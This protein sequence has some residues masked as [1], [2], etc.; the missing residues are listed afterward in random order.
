MQRDRDKSNKLIMHSETWLVKLWIWQCGTSQQNNIL[1]FMNQLF[2]Q[3]FCKEP[4][5]NFQID[6][7][8]KTEIQAQ[9]N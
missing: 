4:N 1:K 6:C 7:D 2:F 5:R 9:K 3:K 8:I